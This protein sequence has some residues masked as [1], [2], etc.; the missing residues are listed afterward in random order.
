MDDLWPWLAVAG[1]GALHGLNPAAGWMLAAASGLR[2]RDPMQ[3]VRALAPLAAGHAASVAL[4]GIAL[5]LGLSLDR[6]WVYV[7]AGGL[8]VLS[9]VLHLWRRAPAAGPVGMLLWSFMMS[10]AHGAGLVLAPAL[11][12]CVRSPAAGT[13]GPLLTALAAVG[14]HMAAMLVVTG[15]VAAGVCRGVRWMRACRRNGKSPRPVA[16]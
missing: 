2:A 16:G 3:A 6:T 8:L 15:L 7:L 1:M 4:A 9:V 11:A 10:T 12:L 14:V 5:A 13:S